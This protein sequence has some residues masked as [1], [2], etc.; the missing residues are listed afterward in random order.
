MIP[1]SLIHRSL[2]DE[3]RSGGLTLPEF[4]SQIEA[5]F[6]EYE[7]SVLAFLPETDRFTRL[8]DE[9]DALAI[10]YPDLI[11]RPLLYG[12]LVGVKDIFQVEGFV[13]QAGSRLPSEVLQ[14]REAESVTRLKEAGALIIGKTVTT[15]FAYFSPGPTRN[16]HN[17]EHT[18]GGSSSGSAAAVAT[19][20]CHVALGT[21]TIGSIIRPASF[22]GVVG[23]KPTYDRISREGVIP[24]SPSLDHVGYFVPDV[25]SAINAARALFKDWDEPSE[26]L[27]KPILGIPDGAYLQSASEDGLAHFETVCVL[28]EN[29]GYE[30]QHVQALSDFADIRSRHDV[31]MSAEAAQV[32]KT[33]FEKY[34]ELYS[35]KFA[36][37][38][39]R[40]QS[41]TDEHL[42]TALRARDDFRAAMKR[43]FLDHN[44]DLW[45]SPSTVGPAPKGLESTGDPIMN[46]PW[47][48]AGLPAMNLPAGRDQDRLPLGLQ[49]VGNWYKDESLLFWAKDLEKVLKTL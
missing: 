24:L 37:L 17:P 12:A 5:R 7:P 29:A 14:G 47:T 20:F 39:R 4:L 25:E 2:I 42:Q 34:E 41:I 1:R 26:V 31:I 33:W 3:L 13:T 15:E 10:S 48:Q 45:I 46:L 27:R 11:K 49:L 40:G 18:P 36:E 16:P 9:A 35:D 21:Q 38:V 22:C 32:H 23:L 28:L 43:L 8:H 30:I 6:L 19:G 44:I